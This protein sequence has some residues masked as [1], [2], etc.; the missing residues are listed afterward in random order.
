MTTR[1]HVYGMT[2]HSMLLLQ[3]AA[4]LPAEK[5]K[6]FKGWFKKGTESQANRAEQVKGPVPGER[7]PCIQ[8]IKHGQVHSALYTDGCR[9]AKLSVDEFC[10]EQ[11]DM[12]CRQKATMGGNCTLP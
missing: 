10:A 2:W 5:G 12:T 4:G 6:Q 8:V 1:D 3:G 7:P 11:S 9:C